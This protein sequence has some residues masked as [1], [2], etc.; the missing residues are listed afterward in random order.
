MTTSVSWQNAPQGSSTEGG[1]QPVLC[2]AS[3]V[4]TETLSVTIRPPTTV[5]KA[6]SAMDLITHFIEL[7]LHLDRH[8]AELVTSY[9]AWVYALLFLIIFCETGLVVTPFLPGD[10][11]LF[12][13]GTLAGAALLDP[14]LLALTLIIAAILGDTV[15][16]W[17]GRRLGP[18]VFESNRSRLFKREHLLRTERFYEKHGGKTVVIARF[19]PI[20]RTFA[21]FVAGIGCMVYGR[22][23]RFNIMGAIAWVVLFVYGGYLFG[24]IPAVKQNLSLV[25][26]AIM[27]LS[28]MPG[29]IEYWRHRSARVK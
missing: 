24:N 16:Y 19:I 15:N 21:P 8:L 25:I 4:Q 22:F 12:V 3:Q 10:S 29:V 27:V 28:V 17:I 9:G 26:L 23:I 2:S 5:R 14:H 18:A 1:R 7:F 13:A 6:L 20:I 11:L